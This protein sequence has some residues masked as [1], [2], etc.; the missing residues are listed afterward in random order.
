[1]TVIRVKHARDYVV[2]NKGALENP[3]LSFKAKGLWAYCMSRPDDWTFNISHLQTVSK[4][5][6]SAIYSAIKEL[7]KEGYCEKSQSR[8]QGRFDSFDYVVSE[9]PIKKMFTLRE[10]PDAENPDVENQAL[11][12]IDPN[13]V[14]KRKNP[15]L[16]P[17]TE[18]EEEPVTQ[19]EEEELNRRFK[20]RPKTAPMVFDK[21]A[22]KA[23]VLKQMRSEAK[24]TGDLLKSNSLALEHYRKVIEYQR[25][26]GYRNID[27]G[28]QYVEL[29]RG[30]VVKQHHVGD[31]DF[32]EKVNDI[33]CMNALQIF[34][35][36][37]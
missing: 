37:P 22:W 27:V 34:E 18:M 1:M 4:D 6:E 31:I 11:L 36:K 26:R 30:Q 3:R 5:K 23:V 20:A 25:S 10:K 9:Q 33:F 16:T 8:K 7:V 12:S 2:I 19:E 32:I 21:K 14:K 15:P 24:D 29:A 13:Q 28:N 35:E 17:S